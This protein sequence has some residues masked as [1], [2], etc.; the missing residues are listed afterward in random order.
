MEFHVGDTPNAEHK[1]TRTDLMRWLDSIL[2]G[3]K[4]PQKR[5]VKSKENA[6]NAER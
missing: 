5:T 1:S 3:T 2:D 6:D 4:L